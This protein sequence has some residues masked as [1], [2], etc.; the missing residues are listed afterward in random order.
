MKKITKYLILGVVILAVVLVGTY[1]ITFAKYVSNTTWNHY[2]KSKKFYFGSDILKE[3]NAKIVNNL[4]DGNAISFHLQNSLSDMEITDY[5]IHY[6]VTCKVTKDTSKKCSVNGSGE[7][8]YEGVL[9]A[10]KACTNMKEDGVDVSTFDEEEC[11]SK[12]YIYTK[13]LADKEIFFE[14]LNNDDIDSE[15]VEIVVT[16]TS[17]YKKTLKGSFVLHKDQSLTGIVKMKYDTYEKYGQLS[18]SNSYDEKKCV[19][20]KWN[21]QDLHFNNSEEILSY[22]TDK[23]GYINEITTEIEAFHNKRYLFYP[24]G[25]GPYDESHFTLVETECN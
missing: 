2:L 3:E 20:I 14:I 5:D 19:K 8:T 9:S 7:D 16:T 23:D 10:F 25:E 13:Q 1:G 4:W 21:A 17:P 11:T 18:L 6:K 15:T 12:G 22:E 24:Q